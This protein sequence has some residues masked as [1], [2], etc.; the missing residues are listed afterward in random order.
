[1]AGIKEATID[2]NG[3]KI[4]VAAASSLGNARTLMNEVREGKSNYHIIEIMACPG[5]CVAGGGQPFHCG[6]YEKI[7]A[8]GRGLYSI[9]ARKVIRKSHENPDIQKLYT[10]FLGEP[11]GEKA[12]KYLH[13][14]Y[15]DK[16]NVYK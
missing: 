11:N 6:D 10:N 13:T 14:H 1:M 12:H 7:K 2:I 3:T 8:R 15:F 16:S 5:G 4:N 9:D